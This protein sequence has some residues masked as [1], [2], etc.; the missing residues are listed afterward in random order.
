MSK[1]D[2][3]SNSQL[4]ENGQPDDGL[5]QLKPTTAYEIVRRTQKALQRL[6]RSHDD[7]M[8]I[9]EAVAIGRAE[10]MAV[11]HTNKPTGK[12]YAEPDVDAIR[13][14]RAF[15]KVALRCFGLRAVPVDTEAESDT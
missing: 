11:T 14:L 12:R 2:V 8:D 13:A 7:W 1:I 15:L 5:R 6:R 3:Q 10:V 4:V 9:A